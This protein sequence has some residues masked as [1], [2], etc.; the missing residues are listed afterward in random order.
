MFFFDSPK[1]L[2][3]LVVTWWFGLVVW[4][5]GIPFWIRDFWVPLESQTTNP[6]HQFSISWN[7][8]TTSETSNAKTGWLKKRH[9]WLVEKNHRYVKGFILV[10]WFLFLKQGIMARPEHTICG[11]PQRRRW[12]RLLA[13]KEARRGTLAEKNSFFRIG[14]CLH[15][16]SLT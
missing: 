9:N 15:P 1:I 8:K 11:K 12:S 2:L 5:P 16:R 4:I 7:K 14:G 3:V 10:T 13:E 6:N